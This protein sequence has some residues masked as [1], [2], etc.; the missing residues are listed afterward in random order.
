MDCGLWTS[1][2]EQGRTGQGRTGDTGTHRNEKRD[3]ENLPL[4]TTMTLTKSAFFFFFF[5]FLSTCPVS[6]VLCSLFFLSFFSSFCLFTSPHFVSLYSLN[7]TSFSFTLPIHF[8][9]T[10]LCTNIQALS[11]P[12]PSLPISVLLF[13]HL[14]TFSLSSFSPDFPPIQ[15]PFLLFQP[16]AHNLFAVKKKSKGKQGDT[17]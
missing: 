5:F 14:A 17:K 7:P 13:L 2:R 8:S 4:W 3:K 1:T 11:T 6:C 10:S 16:H 15:P 12:H 9:F